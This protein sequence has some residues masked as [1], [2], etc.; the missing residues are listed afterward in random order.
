[1][2]DGVAL[3]P[4]KIFTDERGRV[5]HML[6]A[7]DELF[8]KFGEIYFSVVNPGMVKGWKRHQRM[9][10]FFS[11]PQGN[12]KLVIYDDR[13]QSPTRGQVQEILLGEHDYQLVRIPPLV[14]YAVKSIDNK[15]AMIA[16]CT[17]ITHDPKESEQIAPDDPRIPYQWKP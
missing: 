5:M 3:K 17:D 10:Q 8:R 12:L 11:V 15:I 2:I 13:A 4:L 1:V 14:W 16:N 6:R 9:T 7:D